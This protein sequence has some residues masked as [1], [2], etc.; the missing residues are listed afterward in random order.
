MITDINE[1]RHEE[2]ALDSQE[3][4]HHRET[5]SE[6]L[7]KQQLDVQMIYINLFDGHEGTKIK[8]NKQ[9][10]KNTAEKMT[11]EAQEAKST[12]KCVHICVCALCLADQHFF[13]TQKRQP[14]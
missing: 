5:E 13:R 14:E 2:G 4:R 3:T 12:F 6:S 10:E 9:R 7:D 1:E 11:G 8:V